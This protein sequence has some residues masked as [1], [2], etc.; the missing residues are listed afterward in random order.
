MKIRSLIID[1]EPLAADVIQNYLEQLPQVEIV[2]RCTNA[3]EA[4][5]ILSQQAVD[6]IF[7]DINMPQLNGIDFLKSLQHPPLVVITTAYRDYAVESF[8]LN[9]ID[10]LVKPI[11]LHRFLQAM[12]KVSQ[13]MHSNQNRLGVAKSSDSE[14]AFIFLKVDKRMVKV[15]LDEILYIESLKDYVRVHT[16]YEN[17]VT[18]Q[19]LNGMSKLLPADHFIRVHKSYVIALDKVK[20]LEGNSVEIGGKSI[21]LGRNYRKEARLS[22]LRNSAK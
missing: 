12:D 13:I 20:A 6:L 11:P 18:H 17:L 15:F 3:M 8:E 19:N 22:I 16:I 14:K 9:V 10:Y 2:D 7:T 4:F 21:P 1:D 5:S